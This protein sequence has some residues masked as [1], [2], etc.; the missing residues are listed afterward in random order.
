MDRATRATRAI[1]SLAASRAALG[2]YAERRWAPGATRADF[3]TSLTLRF[4]LGLPRGR[5]VLAG[6]VTAL[7]VRR[8]LRAAREER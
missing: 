4:L 5:S 6:W 3:P 1:A 7:V 2:A 8:L